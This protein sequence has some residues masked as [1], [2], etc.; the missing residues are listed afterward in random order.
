MEPQDQTQI[1]WSRRAR[2]KLVLWL[3]PSLLTAGARED[4]V[5]MEDR[6]P[7]MWALVS[8]ERDKVEFHYRDAEGPHSGYNDI[9]PF[10]VKT[11][12]GLVRNCEGERHVGTIAQGRWG[13][14]VSEYD[15]DEVCPALPKWIAWAEKEESSRGVP[16]VQFFKGLKTALE[17]DCIYGCCPLVVPSSFPRSISDWG[18]SEGWGQRLPLPSRPLYN[19]LCLTARE[20]LHMCQSLTADQRWYALTRTSTLDAQ[21]KALLLS[22]GKVLTV[23][24]RRCEALKQRRS[25]RQRR[26]M[27]PSCHCPRP[28]TST[29]GWSRGPAGPRSPPLI[30]AGVGGAGQQQRGAAGWA[31]LPPAR[32]APDRHAGDWDTSAHCIPASTKLHAQRQYCYN[33]KLRSRASCGKHLAVDIYR[34]KDSQPLQ[35]CRMW[36]S[37]SLLSGYS[38]VSALLR[39]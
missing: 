4:D 37:Y 36:P 18:R 8:I 33:Y 21:T 25:S 20:Q 23:F 11:K 26:Q 38:K 24:R 19:L 30:Q 32:A 29:G 17:L 7:T 13:I 28:D 10:L 1:P 9:R 22:L 2:R 6:R 12:D 39:Q 16:S 35:S 15:P 27:R 5:E 3:A 14:L 34:G 31:R